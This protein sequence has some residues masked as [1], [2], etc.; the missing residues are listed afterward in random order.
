MPLMN[1]KV[2]LKLRWTKHCVL[3]AAGVENDNANSS[4]IIR[5]KDTYM[6]LLLLYQQK[7][8]KNYQNF[9]AKNLKDQCIGMSIQ[10]KV[11]IKI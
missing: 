3:A 7:T 2:E 10:Q 8:V 4:N 11:R 5:H 9:I 6:P 1:C